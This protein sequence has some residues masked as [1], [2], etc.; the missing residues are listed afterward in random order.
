MNQAAG[1]KSVILV[2]FIYG[3]WPEYQFVNDLAVS[4]SG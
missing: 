4:E 3:R 2:I 1:N